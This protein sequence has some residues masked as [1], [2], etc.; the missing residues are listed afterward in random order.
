MNKEEGLRLKPLNMPLRGMFS[1]GASA[2]QI[3][4]IPSFNKQKPPLGGLCLLKTLAGEEGFEPSDG[5]TKTS[6]LTTWRLPNLGGR[7]KCRYAG[8]KLHKRRGS[9]N[10]VLCASGTKRKGTAV[11]FGGVFTLTWLRWPWHARVRRGLWSG[12]YLPAGAW[13][14][15]RLLYPPSLHRLFSA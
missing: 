12:W 5:W 14:L 4:S 3:F 2:V 13:F 9:V 1:N 10:G 15:Q 6:C 8:G 11:P 7:A